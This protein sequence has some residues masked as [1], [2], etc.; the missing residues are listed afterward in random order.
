MLS[1]LCWGRLKAPIPNITGGLEFPAREYIG[2][3]ACSGAISAN[4][5]CQAGYTY[6]AWDQ[7]VFRRVTI[8]AARISNIFGSSGF[9]QM[10]SAQV[11]MIIKT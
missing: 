10:T 7:G 2:V 1:Q 4:I 8:D 3:N 9:V 11:L 5:S 6:S